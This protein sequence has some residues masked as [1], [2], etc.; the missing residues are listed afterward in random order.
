[1]AVIGNVRIFVALPV[2]DR[3]LRELEDLQDSIR[4]CG[5]S[6]SFPKVSSIHLTL[7]FLGDTPAADIPRI[8]RFLEEYVTPF[9]EFEIGVKRVGVFPSPQRPR[10]VWAGIVADGL[11]NALQK[12]VESGMG[13]AGYPPDSRKFRPHLTLARIKSTRKL[14][15]L[16]AV[17]ES[18]EDFDGGGFPA[19][20]VRLYQSIL[21]PEG[22]EYR[23]L[24]EFRAS[25]RG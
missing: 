21:R 6:A 25:G 12:R 17:L 24:A 15:E 20:S 10:V 11:L 18:L 1:M 16:S 13:E 7:K 4:A 8:E 3:I 5:V 19:A 2:P 23:V 14:K 22:A 9:E